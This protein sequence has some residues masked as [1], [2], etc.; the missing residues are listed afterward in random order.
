MLKQLAL[1]T[2]LTLTLM[3][4][5]AAHAQRPGQQPQ[6]NPANVFAASEAAMPPAE[7]AKQVE[8]MASALSSLQPQ[9]PGVV[10]T[11]ILSASFWNDPVFEAEAKEAAAILGRRYDA[12]DRTIILSAG[13]GG[14]SARAYPAATPNNFQAALGK[15]GATIDPAED[16]VIIFMTSH[17]AQDGTVAIQEKGRMEGGLRV[18]PLRASL[19]QAGIRNK[20]IIVS[21]CFSGHFIAPFLSD[22]GAVVLTAA[23]ADRTSFGCEPNR[24]WTYFGDALFNH[25]LRGGAG[26]VESYNDALKLITAWEDDLRVKWQALPAAQKKQSPEPQP[27][28]PQSNIGDAVETVV[29]K[30]ELYG[31]AVNCAG[32]LGF[33]LDRAKTGRPLKGL[34]DLQSLQT[35]RT[36]IEARAGAE[37]IARKRSQQ[38]TAKAI[39]ASAAS[40]LQVFSAQPS[41]VTAHA[42]RCEA[43]GQGG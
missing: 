2:A 6:I 33:A 37:G 30:A 19:Q 3:A 10:D 20:V 29:A 36:A 43:M 40:V 1:T 41:D 26:L 42:A 16:L 8:M 23:G 14:G 15:I 35:A 39:A 28:N 18:L 7:A 4:A 17:G 11:Y 13:R 21:A 9:R 5:G 27:S 31:M 12:G 22:P 38:E 25:A 24:E 32:H 34:A